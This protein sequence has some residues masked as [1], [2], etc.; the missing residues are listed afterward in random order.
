MGLVQY[1][2]NQDA[3]AKARQEDIDGATGFVQYAQTFKNGTT[4]IRIMPAWSD[5]GVWFEPIT[6]HFVMAKKKSFVCS[7]EVSG[8][9]PICE[10]GK[11]LADS[12]QEEAAKNF[13]PSTKY[14]VNAIVLSEPS[15]KLSIKDGIKV[16]KLP[17][18][19]KTTL[20]DFDVDASGDG[21]GD[22][23]DYFHGVNIKVDR[24]GQGLGTKYTVKPLPTRVDIVA[25]LQEE[26]INVESLQ[27]N[28]LDEMFPAKTYE[29]LSDEFNAVTSDA[30]AETPEPVDTR[31]RPSVGTTVGPATSAAVAAPSLGGFV[32]AA[33]PKLNVQIAPP[34]VK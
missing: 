18:G 24:A 19:V 32:A 22:I 14:L 3:L 33:A 7:K 28:V 6:E 10:H 21:W 17:S 4:T 34:V 31:P 30:P 20:L 27:L 11:A 23:T 12:G 9:C 13:R 5:K 8:R 2:R 29:E 16:Y 15:G 25:R 26:G 1:K